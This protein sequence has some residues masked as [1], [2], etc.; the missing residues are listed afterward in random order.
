VINGHFDTGLNNWIGWIDPNSGAAARFKVSDMVGPDGTPSAHVVISNTYDTA[1]V[2]LRQLNKSTVAHREYTV[3]FW[4]RSSQAS[5]PIDVQLI[6][7]PAPWIGTGFHGQATLTPQWQLFRLSGEALRTRSDL[8]L[9]FQLGSET[10]KVWLDDIQF[11]E[12]AAGVWARSFE[13]GL[14]VINPGSVAQTVSLPRF[15]RKL[16]G[17]QAPLFQARLDDNDLIVNGNWIKSPASF[18]QFGSTVYTTTGPNSLA[19][20]TYQ[21]N[22]LYSGIYHVLAWVVPTITQSSGVSITL[23]HAGGRTTITLD[24]TQGPIGWR[25]LGAYRFNAGSAGRAV[26]SATGNGLVVADAFKWIS[27]ARYNDGQA[28][29]QLDLQPQ[30]A[31]VLLKGHEHF[32]PLVAANAP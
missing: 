13:N 4:G 18:T 15:Y 2:E 17:S 20:V 8:R 16:S 22:L 25:D 5:H 27:A 19:T 24:E 32:L 11:Q 7:D 26:L 28:V 14:V 6:V 12:G 30:D 23:D 31:V 10:G 1:N 21:P 9:V 29:K 3:S